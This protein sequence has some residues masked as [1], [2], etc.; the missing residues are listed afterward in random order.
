MKTKS[1]RTAL[2]STPQFIVAGI[3]LFLIEIIG[4]ILTPSY[5][6]KTIFILLHML[7]CHECGH[8]GML[9]L[10]GIPIRTFQLYHISSEKG[11]DGWKICFRFQTGILGQVT[12]DLNRIPTAMLLSKQMRKALFRYILGGPLANIL[13]LAAGILIYLFTRKI[14]GVIIIVVNL[15]AILLTLGKNDNAVADLRAAY[16][17]QTDFCFYCFLLLCSCTAHSDYPDTD[18]LVTQIACQINTMQPSAYKT[19]LYQALMEHDLQSSKMNLSEDTVKLLKDRYF[20]DLS[21]KALTNRCLLGEILVK[22][23]DIQNATAIYTSLPP[24]QR[25][26]AGA[27][28]LKSALEQSCTP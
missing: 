27:I 3:F 1:N 21:E 28:K 16:D 11:S 12:A 24:E 5:I 2:L 10:M 14:T 25:N 6:G 17:I 8:A 15:A 18:S 7:F 26:C 13:Y 20:G 22:Y 4:I 23:E 19:R 9:L